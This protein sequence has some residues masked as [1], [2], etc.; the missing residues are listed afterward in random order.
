MLNALGANPAAPFHVGMDSVSVPDH[1]ALGH[2]IVGLAILTN[3]I[4]INRDWKTFD[5]LDIVPAGI[6]LDVSL[7]EQDD[8]TLYQFVEIDIE[9]RA[10]CHCAIHPKSQSERPHL[11]EL[12]PR[13]A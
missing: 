1:H 3:I 12:G 5:Q 13:R 2:Q 10:L 6:L 8:V 9:Q 4:G 11:P 7:R